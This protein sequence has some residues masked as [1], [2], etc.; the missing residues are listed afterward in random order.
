MASRGEIYS[1][2]VDSENRT[3]FFNVK[4]NRKGDLFLN[5]VESNKKGTGFDRHQIM[6][7]EEELPLFVERFNKAAAI[8]LKKK[9]LEP[10]PRQFKKKSYQRRSNNASQP[11]SKPS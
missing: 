10:A 8:I 5:I 4:E 7:Y 1:T 2:R 3:Y 11:Q 6:V 9:Q